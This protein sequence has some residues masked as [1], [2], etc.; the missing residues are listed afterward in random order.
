MENIQNQPSFVIQK[1]YT[2]DVSFESINSPEIFKAQWEPKVDF[3]IDINSR[4]IDDNNYEVD[5][6]VTLNTKTGETTYRSGPLPVFISTYNR[7][8]FHNK[9]SLWVR[10]K[11][12]DAVYKKVNHKS[13][14]FQLSE[15]NLTDKD[16]NLVS[17]SQVPGRTLGLKDAPLDLKA[18]INQ[19]FDF[20]PIKD[21]NA[22]NPHE[23][24]GTKKPV[25]SKQEC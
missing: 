18:M 21:Q 15:V 20:I 5:L 7:K 9:R 13:H 8:A 3:N 17:S 23:F 12:H 11:L 22:L 10:I 2:K 24:L 16:G 14:G 1:V 6:T 4:K 25:T 19:V